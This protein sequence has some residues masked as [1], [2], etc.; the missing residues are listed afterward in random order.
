MTREET[1]C[2]VLV[3]GGGVAGLF[4]LD[5]LARAGFDPLLIEAGRLGTGQTSSSQGILHG[6]LK[7]ALDGIVG[8]SSTSIATMP[9]RWAS[10][11][12]GTAAPDLSDVGVHSEHC[13]L[14]RTTTLG[15]RLGMIAARSALKAKP[16]QVDPQERPEVLAACPGSVAV[17]D[18]TVIDPISLLRSLADRHQSRLLAIDGPDRMT[19]QVDQPGQVESLQLHDDQRV[20]VIR[21]T[22]VVLAA[23]SGNQKLLQDAGCSQPAMQR[24][25]LRMGMLRGDLPMLWG[26]CVDGARTRITVS[27]ATDENG[28]VVWQVGG[29]VSE[30]GATMDHDR[31]LEHL[32]SEIR[33][34]IPGLDTSGI[35]WASYMVDRAEESTSGSKRPHQYTI[36]H[37]SGNMLTCWPTKLVMAPLLADDVVELIMQRLEP[38][39]PAGARGD[40]FNKW[41]RPNVAQPPWELQSCWTDD[42][43]VATAR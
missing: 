43:S 7:Y 12:Q 13:Y 24:R 31:F 6:G 16:R 26:H 18:E 8:R 41:P 27:S 20:L 22:L 11:L 21:P 1:T 35:Q 4:I 9:V 2:D 39:A 17:V 10:M 15:S 38:G 30:D 14:W 34:T 40:T 37:Q 29:Q 28:R 36:N 5:A 32:Q 3:L 25:P 23:G 19:I 33:A 42:N